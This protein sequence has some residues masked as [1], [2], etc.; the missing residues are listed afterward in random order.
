MKPEEQAVTF[1]RRFC[2]GDVAGLRPLLD[3][4][5]KFRG[6]FVTFAD[7]E[8][9]LESLAAD[10]LDQTSYEII[11]ILTNNHS[12]CIFYDYLKPAGPLTIA[13]LFRF[14]KYK[15]SEIRLVFDTSE[16]SSDS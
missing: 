12:V 6:P 3:E 15:I 2:A 1:V 4:H 5:L 16:F 14:T 11:E 8:S 7:R 9:Y 13:Q 10:S